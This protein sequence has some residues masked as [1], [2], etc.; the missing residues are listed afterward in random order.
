MAALA[1][2]F[3]AYR[4]WYVTKWLPT[5]IEDDPEEGM[6][7]YRKNGWDDPLRKLKKLTRPEVADLVK[8]AGPLPKAYVE[9]L[10]TVGVGPL[11]SAYDE[12]PIH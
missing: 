11:L 12:E 7:D 1:E 5:M 8:T 10:T 2:L 6:A 9:L 4:R 3:E